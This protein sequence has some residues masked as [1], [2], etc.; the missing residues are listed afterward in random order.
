MLDTLFHLPSVAFTHNAE[1]CGNSFFDI[2][3]QE[4]PALVLFIRFLRYPLGPELN[5]L[6]NDFKNLHLLNH[7]YDS[8]NSNNRQARRPYSSFKSACIS[9]STLATFF[10][11]AGDRYCSSAILATSIFPFSSAYLNLASR[12][13]YFLTLKVARF[14]WVRCTVRV[15]GVSIRPLL[16]WDL[17][18]TKEDLNITTSDSKQKLHGA[19]MR[20]EDASAGILIDSDML[21]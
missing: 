7:S 6:K 4:P 5:L 15:A 12:I 21:Q 16:L 8:S 3:S 13:P 1:R 9:G 2:L 19:T 20:G 17:F 10:T 11:G 18:G 14:F